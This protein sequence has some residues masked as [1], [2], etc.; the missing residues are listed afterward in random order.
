MWLRLTQITTGLLNT[1]IRRAALVFVEEVRKEFLTNSDH[2]FMEQKRNAPNPNSR[3][4]NWI[5]TWNNP[6]AFADQ[7]VFVQ[8]FLEPN[9]QRIQG[10]AWQSE[11]G[12]EGTLH[13]QIAL[14]FK[15]PIT[16][17]GLKRLRREPHWEPIKHG[18]DSAERYCT[19]EDTRVDGPFFWPGPADE[20]RPNRQ[21]KRSDL[22]ELYKLA[23]SG[24]DYSE[25]IALAPG[26]AIRYGDAVLNAVARSKA[27][28]VPRAPLTVGV[29]YGEPGCGKSH[30]LFSPW[31]EGRMGPD[32]AFPQGLSTWFD[33][34][35]G[36]RCLLFDDFDPSV[37]T[38][39]YFLKLLDRWPLVVGVKG[40]SRW[41]SWDTVI[42]T[43]N[44]PFQDWEFK[45]EDKRA[46]NADQC[47]AV[48]RRINHLLQF[49][50]DDTG[51]VVVTAHR[52]SRAELL[53]RYLGSVQHP[54]GQEDEH[55]PEG[56]E[57]E[58]D[59]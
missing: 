49:T 33:G 11:R 39:A 59:E 32:Q 43:S 25:L 10:C 17:G 7:P 3:H 31:L 22:E 15:H 9:L 13:L 29:L 58:G 35:N 6:G 47:Y 34:Y 55:Q 20:W 54:E 4:R 46:P 5:G 12:E 8:D 45:G 2:S 19:K 36:Q 50:R 1:P 53:S 38:R 14:C 21:G 42:I 40:G 57:E 27:V 41:A 26:S 23:M 18:W 24:A 44:V 16:F 48:D 51:E 56:Q 28:R 30:F 37:W 52:G